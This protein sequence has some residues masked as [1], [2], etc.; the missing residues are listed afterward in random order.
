[1]IL[2]ISEDSEEV[3]SG[4]INKKVDQVQHSISAYRRRY[5]SRGTK[6]MPNAHSVNLPGP[7]PAGHAVGA[8]LVI[9]L[10]HIHGAGGHET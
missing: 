5:N 4:V 8:L 9:N 7:S 6:V 3:Q 1:M 2:T 10:D